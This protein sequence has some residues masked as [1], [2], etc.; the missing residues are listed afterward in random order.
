MHRTGAKQ[1]ALVTPGPQR[2]NFSGGMKVDTGSPNVIGPLSLIVAHVVK[3]F[4]VHWDVDLHLKV[5]R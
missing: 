1:F 4:F 2:E 3:L 5:R